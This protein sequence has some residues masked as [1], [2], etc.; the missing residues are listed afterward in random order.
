MS[1]FL[2]IRERDEA[3]HMKIIL[4]FIE[5]VRLVIVLHDIEVHKVTEHFLCLIWKK[6]V[7]Y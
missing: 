4:P 2:P 5:I 7:K 6:R 3:I 1:K